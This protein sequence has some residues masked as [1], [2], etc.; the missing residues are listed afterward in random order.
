MKAKKPRKSAFMVKINKGSVRIR[1]ERH[2]LAKLEHILQ[3]GGVEFSVHHETELHP[4]PGMG[5]VTFHFPSQVIHT[6][7]HAMPS[8]LLV[9]V[10]MGRVECASQDGLLR[11]EEVW[12]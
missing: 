1:V 6:T 10:R 3:V 2:G 8:L 9:L 11:L 4:T 12:E 5:L 7:S